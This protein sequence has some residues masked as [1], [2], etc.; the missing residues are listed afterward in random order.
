MYFWLFFNNIFVFDW[1]ILKLFYL[2]LIIFYWI[3]IDIKLSGFYVSLILMIKVKDLKFCLLVFMW[4]ISWWV[5]VKLYKKGFYLV[6]IK[7][8]VLMSIVKKLWWIFYVLRVWVMVGL[9]KKC[10]FWSCGWGII[11][12]EIEVVIIIYFVFI[13]FFR[14]VIGYYMYDLSVIEKLIK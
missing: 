4:F 13:C 2:V 3:R 8:F 14:D 10:Y 6:F 9:F 5:F 12:D 1:Y 7:I 11:I